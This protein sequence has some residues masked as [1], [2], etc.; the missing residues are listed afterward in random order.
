MPTRGGCRKQK[1]PPSANRERSEC[2]SSSADGAQSEAEAK[3]TAGVRQ[4]VQAASSAKWA[5]RGIP[6]LRETTAIYPDGWHGVH[7]GAFV[8][9]QRFSLKCNLAKYSGGNCLLF[10]FDVATFPLMRDTRQQQT[11]IFKLIITFP[12]QKSSIYPVFKN[13][14]NPNLFWL[15]F[16]LLKKQC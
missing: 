8:A 9:A 14:K 16:P 1:C 15:G 12:F 7:N 10:Y 13:K 11:P 2:E 6:C 5:G 3:A 4:K